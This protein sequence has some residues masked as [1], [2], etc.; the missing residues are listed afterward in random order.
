MKLL[1][2]F[3]SVLIVI[4][5]LIPGSQLPN[6]SIGGYDK[7]IHIIMFLTWALAVR[8]DYDSQPFRYAFGFLLGLIF[9]AF[10]ELLQILV[11]GRSFDINDMA[12]DAI[13]LIIGFAI[14][15]PVVRWVK[16]LRR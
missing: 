13:G 15:G 12:A 4:A 8:F 1:T 7:L 9:S 6:V 2:A 16:H 11:E 10:T 3:V 5:V 14:S